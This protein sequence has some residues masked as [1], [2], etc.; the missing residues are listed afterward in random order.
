[1]PGPAPPGRRGC[2]WPPCTGSSGCCSSASPSSSPSTTSTWCRRCPCRPAAPQGTAGVVAG[3]GIGVVAAV[4]GVAGGELRI[5]TITV[6]HAVDVRLAGSLSLVVSLP[7]ML[8]AFARYSRDQAFVVLRR[9]ARPVVAMAAGSVVGSVA[10]GLL[11]GVVPEAVLV[12]VV[13]ALPL[14]SAVETWGHR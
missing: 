5:P 12:P 1:M 11:A 8:V 10:G 7:T 13:V 14:L 3:F 6:L 4:L 9:H 2:G